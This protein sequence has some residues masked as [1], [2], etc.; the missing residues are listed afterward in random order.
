MNSKK[1]AQHREPL[2]HITKRDAPAWYLGIAARAVAIIA[3]LIVC[4]AVIVFMTGLNPLDVY[5]KMFEGSFGTERK[6][7]IL[8]Q[9][10]AMLLCISL[11]VTPA[12]KMKFWNL[13]AEGQ[14][15]V[16][17]L[18]SAA[19]MFY[20]KDSLPNGVLIPLM[21]VASIVA[22]IIWAVVPAIFKAQWGTN[23]SLFTLMMNY[24]AM[25]LVAFFIMVWVPSGSSVMGIINQKSESGWLPQL[26]GQKYGFN[27][28]IVA[29]LTVALYIYLK[30][31][32]QGYEISVVGESENTA[33]YIGINVKKVI[34]RT[35]LVSGA[36]C[37]IAGFLL[38]SGTNHTISKDIAGGMGF[39]AIM[40]S[41]LAKFNPGMMVITS[42]L[43][44]FLERGSGEIAT[45]FRLNQSVSDILTGIIIFFIIGC[46]FFINYKINM[47]SKH[48][49]G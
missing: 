15:L 46:E 34:I 21:L 11:A 42:F 38:V 7:W 43:I 41:W 9:E 26:F 32:K 36:I 17:G 13:G 5:T 6:M 10:I 24:V 31:S 49:E 28:L 20:A 29:L 16:G 14:V 4:S 40:V 22:G 47:R 33:R 48:K 37:G 27:I 39:T 23:E 44:V 45:A 1:L 19:C 8:L 2:L 12:F 25:Q 18:A 35:L 30:Y 3:A